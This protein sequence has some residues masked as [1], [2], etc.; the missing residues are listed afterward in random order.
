MK[1]AGTFIGR[2]FSNGLFVAVGYVW[3]THGIW[4]AL[5]LD[6]GFIVGAL[7]LLGVAKIIEETLD[8]RV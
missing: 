6:A 2:Q 3:A 8:E 7:A 5:A 4:W 1:R